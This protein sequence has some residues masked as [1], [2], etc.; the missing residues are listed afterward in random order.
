MA[1]I[2]TEELQRH[3][4]AFERALPDYMPKTGGLQTVVAEAMTYACTDGG[5][6]IRP[7]LTLEFCRLCGGD[8][9]AAMPFAMAIEMIHS[10]SLVHDDLPCMDNSPMRRGKPSA[11]AAYGETMALLAG[12]GLLNRAFEVCLDPMNSS[13]LKSE[14]ILKATYL[15]GTAAGF[16]GMIGGQTIDLANEGQ[17]IDEDTLR[18]LHRKK[19]GALLV[20]ACQLGAVLAD[21]DEAVVS[22]A[23]TYGAHL[24]LCF[25]IIDDVLDATA[26]ADQL[27]KPVGA[28]EINEKTTYVSLFGLDGA[29]EMARQETAAALDALSDFGQEANDLRALT[30]ALLT[31]IV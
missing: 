24:G 9:A 25:Q 20:A 5:K 23:E 12:D 8:V 21:A 15:L 4:E 2:Y 28:D 10:Y 7:V 3:L 11:H 14:N 18:E 1:S 31:R 13:G 6:R 27:G 16:D 19:T 17:R 29:V 26:T 22:A 30:E